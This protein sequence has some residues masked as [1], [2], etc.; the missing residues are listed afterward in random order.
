MRASEFDNFIMTADFPNGEWRELH[1][2]VYAK[3]EG[4]VCVW[5]GIT[6]DGRMAK[7][8]MGLM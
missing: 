5:Y 4:G 7:W 2:S 8:L 1:L 3:A 6:G